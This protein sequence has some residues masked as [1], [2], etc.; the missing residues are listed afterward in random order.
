[1]MPPYQL[2]ADGFESQFGV[3]HLGHFALTSL[4][5]DKLE[6]GK[7]S[8]VVSTSSI[9]HRGG[10]IRLDDINAENGYVAKERYGIS[11]LANLLSAY[12]LQRRLEAAGRL[13]LSVA[14]HPGIANTELGRF[15]PSWV[16]LIALI[17]TPMLNTPASGTWPTLRA[18]TDPGARGGDF[19]GPSKR[20]ETAGPATLCRS[21]KT[22][23]DKALAAQL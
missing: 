23:H 6:A 19:F 11:K 15:F 10:T 13:T 9:A 14:C 17:M 4:L 2:T 20:W 7:N 18:A 1:M 16:K 22:S 8:R 5:L 3:N 12:E 21:D